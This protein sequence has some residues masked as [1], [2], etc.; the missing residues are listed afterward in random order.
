MIFDIALV[1]AVFIAVFF[2]LINTIKFIRGQS[3]SSY[4][5]IFWALG[6]TALVTHFMGIW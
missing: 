5:F 2:T 1:I 6:L 4:N 3:I